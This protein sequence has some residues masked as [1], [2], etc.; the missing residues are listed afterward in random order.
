MNILNTPRTQKYFA[1]HP[2][3]EI[4]NG[5]EI[6][7]AGNGMFMVDAAIA[8]HGITSNYIEDCREFINKLVSENIK[9]YDDES[10]TK[11]IFRKK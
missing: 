10:V 6:R 11:Y 7:D 2:I 1:K 8:I 3:I 5:Y 9:Q 4:Y